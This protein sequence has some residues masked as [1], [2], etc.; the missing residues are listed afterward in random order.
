[1]SSSVVLEWHVLT[2]F[3]WAH[4]RRQARESVNDVNPSLPSRVSGGDAAVAG[5]EVKKTLPIP[6]FQANPNLRDP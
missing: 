1:M 2:R 6:N 5:M 4:T 3:I